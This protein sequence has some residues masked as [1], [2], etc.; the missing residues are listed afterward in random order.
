MR[1]DLQRANKE[2]SIR[3]RQLIE[4]RS[5]C[6]A[7]RKEQN[8]FDAKLKRALGVARLLRPYQKKIDGAMICL[9]ETETRLNFAKGQSANRLNA[10]VSRR[11][12]AKH[13]QELLIKSIQSNQQKMRSIV[14]DIGKIRAE[15]VGEW[16]VFV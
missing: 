11:D 1:A 10:A 14:D 4:A 13:R 16:F 9:N 2:L 3:H 6:D 12:D 5:R 8:R 7:S 15:I